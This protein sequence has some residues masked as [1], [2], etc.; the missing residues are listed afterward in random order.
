MQVSLHMM[1]RKTQRRLFYSDGIVFLRILPAATS[2]WDLKRTYSSEPIFFLL[3]LVHM[4]H[5]QTQM[6]FQ[7]KKFDNF[8][9]SWFFCWRIP[10]WFL[11][12]LKLLGLKLKLHIKANSW[13][14]MDC[15]CQLGW[16]EGL[17]IFFYWLFARKVSTCFPES[18]SEKLSRKVGHWNVTR[19]LP[20]VFAKIITCNF[21][22]Y[23]RV[24]LCLELVSQQKQSLFVS[25][26]IAA[27]FSGNFFCN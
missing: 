8:L 24:S 9:W 25:D 2:L 4:Q 13:S 3:K 10:F 17:T 18:F 6:N 1:G 15:K 14:P 5:T 22:A 19:H 26:D 11:I 27:L 20:F 7:R 23:V 16:I 21:V 12:T